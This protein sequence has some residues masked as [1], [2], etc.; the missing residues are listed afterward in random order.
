MFG[1]TF[2]DVAEDS[3]NDISTWNNDLV[4]PTHLVPL[5]REVY[6]KPSN[7]IHSSSFWQDV[8]LNLVGFIPFGFFLCWQ[9]QLSRPQA[10][11]R[12]VLIATTCC[13]SLSLVIETAQIWLPGRNSSLLDLLLN[14]FGALLGIGLFEIVKRVRRTTQP[15]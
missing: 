13:V 5:K 1:Y 10:V 3:I 7:N 8:L 15:S 12:S 14:S 9:L 6:T 11:W 4:L 2:S